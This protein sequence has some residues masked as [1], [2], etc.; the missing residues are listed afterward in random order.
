MGPGHTQPDEPGSCPVG[1]REAWGCPT[2]GGGHMGCAHEKTLGGE[3]SS[4]CRERT[5]PGR[6]P[7]CRLLKSSRVEFRRAWVGAASGITEKG[8][9][10]CLEAI[11]NSWLHENKEKTLNPGDQVLS[12]Y[13]GLLLLFFLLLRLCMQCMC[14]HVYMRVHLYG[15]NES[16]ACQSTTISLLELSASLQH[17]S[18]GLGAFRMCSVVFLL[19]PGPISSCL[20]PL[21]EASWY[22]S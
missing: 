19:G 1:H 20:N 21:A 14:A 4:V 11:R 16:S 3:P 8:P 5:G 12:T 2:K 17:P 15:C 6:G 13:N 10:S 9:G 22:I 7:N 18:P